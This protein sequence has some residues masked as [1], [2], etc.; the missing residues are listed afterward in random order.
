MPCFLEAVVGLGD[1]AK[2]VIM[3]FIYIDIYNLYSQSL[4]TIKGKQGSK[5][6]TFLSHMLPKCNLSDPVHPKI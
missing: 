6:W 3:I 4:F 5:L 2:N 1:T